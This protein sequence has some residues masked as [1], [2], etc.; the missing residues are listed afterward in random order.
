MKTI[1]IRD[2]KMR[3]SPSS[4]AEMG[5]KFSKNAFLERKR[6]WQEIE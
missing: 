2:A 6:L 4:V 5:F 3:L 1:Q